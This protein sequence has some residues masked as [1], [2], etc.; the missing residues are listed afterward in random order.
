MTRRVGAYAMAMLQKRPPTEADCG[1]QRLDAG[2]L[3]VGPDSASLQ[4]HDLQRGSVSSG[5]HVDRG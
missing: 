3:L 1:T 4:E 2:G 5:G